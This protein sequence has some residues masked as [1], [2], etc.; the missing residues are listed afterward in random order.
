METG[1]LYRNI[2]SRLPVEIAE[3]LV[4]SKC[5]RIERIV[6]KG[7][8]SSPDFWY[9]QKENEW[10]L[11][12][13]GEATLCFEQGKRMLHLT[14]GMYVHIGAHEK[15]RVE[16]TRADAETIWLAIFYPCTP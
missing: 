16:S 6:S 4:V 5:L 15:H 12:V 1:N 11:L 14:E 9:D 2:P 10:V 8:C 3:S 7:H 13:K